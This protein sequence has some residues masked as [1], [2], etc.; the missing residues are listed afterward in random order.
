MQIPVIRQDFLQR[1]AVLL[2]QSY[3]QLLRKP[4]LDKVAEHDLA[5]QLFNAPFAIVSHD[6]SADPVFNYGNAC[7]LSLFEFTFEEFITLPSRFSA[8]PVNRLERE[9]LLAEVTRQGFINNY[10]GIRISKMGRRFKISNAVV[11]NLLDAQQ[12]YCG[13]AA[14]FKDWQFL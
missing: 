12:V 1:H 10:Q 14:C 4:L 6:T 7:A 2:Q 3:Q 13:Q 5:L 9:Q 11:W 8:E